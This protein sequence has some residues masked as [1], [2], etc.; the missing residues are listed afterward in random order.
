MAA[1]EDMES[2][3]EEVRE[4]LKNCKARKATYY[5]PCTDDNVVDCLIGLQEELSL[6]NIKYLFNPYLDL[7]DGILSKVALVR[8]VNACWCLLQ[9]HKQVSDNGCKSKDRTY[10]LE[11]NN[12]FLNN[13][14]DQ[15]RETIKSKESALKQSMCAADRLTEKATATEKELA[16]CKAELKRVKKQKESKEHQLATELKRVQ[17][18]FD[19]LQ[20]K[21]RGQ[22]GVYTSKNE[23]KNTFIEEYRMREKKYKETIGKLQNTNRQLIDEVLALKEELLLEAFD[24]DSLAGDTLD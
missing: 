20:D 3:D 24:A 22:C 16:E 21:F 10:A 5:E 2:L 11:Q 4:L 14:V 6:F 7:E 17:R 15:L 1:F 8:L 13:T 9:H 12:Y 23:T 19:V 18:Q